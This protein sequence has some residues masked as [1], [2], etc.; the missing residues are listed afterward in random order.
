MKPAARS[1][2]VHRL[3]ACRD[4]LGNE[5]PDRYGVTITLRGNPIKIDGGEF[6]TRDEAVAAGNLATGVD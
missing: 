6:N 5:Y 2:T 4:W 1:F 3:P